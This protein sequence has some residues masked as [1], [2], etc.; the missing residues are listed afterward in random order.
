VD[1]RILGVVQGLPPPSVPEWV[2]PD[3]DAVRE[4]YRVSFD[5]MRRGLDSRDRG[6]VIALAWVLIGE[7]SPITGRRGDETSWEHARAESWV[8]LCLAAGQGPPTERDWQRLGITPKPALT[9]DRE[10]AYG[11]WRTLAW[12]LGVREDWP[13]HTAWHQAAEIPRERP[14]VY[15]PKNQRDTDAWRAADQ[16]SRDQAQR[17]ARRYW[18]HVRALADATGAA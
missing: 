10:F 3:A 9:C 11:V 1:R 5:V 18:Q 16:A 6:V 8:A 7:Q 4:C 2:L 12:L 14:H 15:V 17:D 13:L